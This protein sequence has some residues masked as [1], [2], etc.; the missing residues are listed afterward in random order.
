MEKDS[1]ILS[2]GGGGKGMRILAMDTATK[3]GSVA[4]FDGKQLVGEYILNIAL[5][6][7]EKLIPAIG[8]LMA[9]VGWQ[10]KDLDGIVVTL[11]PG[12]FTG[13]RIGITTGKTLA[14]VWGV[15]LVG[16][17]TLDVLAFQGTPFPG[18]IC[19]ILDARRNEVYTGLY[20][21]EEVIVRPRAASLRD[22]LDKIGGTKTLFIGDGVH[23][24]GEQ[25]KAQMGDQAFFAPGDR[26]L[27]RASSVGVLGAKKLAR[28]EKIDLMEMVPIYLRRSEAEITWE[29]KCLGE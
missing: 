17:L 7:S 8:R 29:R 2:K 9:D 12:S 13:L 6:H 20:Q 1:E 21:G 5:T 23:P 25:I 27:I 19:P 18:L 16:V 11:G 3:T 10:G 4:L 26:N 22:L 28:G 15:D 14:Y 24:Y